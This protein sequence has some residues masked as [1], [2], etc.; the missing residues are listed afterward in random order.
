MFVGDFG[1]MVPP[2]ASDF[3]MS[4]TSS[5][6]PAVFSC[7]WSPHSFSTRA[8]KCA[9]LLGTAPV[10]SGDRQLFIVA[11]VWSTPHPNITVIMRGL[12]Q[13]PSSS[14]RSSRL[15]QSREQ[16][17][18][19]SRLA[20]PSSLGVAAKACCDPG[21]S[22]TLT[23]P[24]HHHS[25]PSCHLYPSPGP[26]ASPVIAHHLSSCRGCG[27]GGVGVVFPLLQGVLVENK[28]LRPPSRPCSPP[29]ARLL[30]P[31]AFSLLSRP[32]RQQAPSTSHH[33]S[34]WPRL[35]WQWL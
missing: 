2:A 6:L 15:P 1:E 16:T 5:S 19:L 7:L 14:L 35:W 3:Q 10:P 30:P 31:A 25:F 13:P 20:W 27:G 32:Q 9:T 26:L 28:C 4:A 29:R 24:Q 33:P 17:T 22:P 18:M 11:L 34:T 21:S 23:P 8:D 12:Y